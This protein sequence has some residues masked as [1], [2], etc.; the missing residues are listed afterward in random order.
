MR[1]N[2]QKKRWGF[3]IFSLSNAYDKTE[4][5]FTRKNLFD[6][7]VLLWLLIIS[8]ILITVMSGSWVTS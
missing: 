7:Q 5:S 8:F 4:M 6:N 2:N 1:N 3:R